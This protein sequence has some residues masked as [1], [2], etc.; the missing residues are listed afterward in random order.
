MLNSLPVR[1]DGYLVDGFGAELV[2]V[3]SGG[4]PSPPT[5]T[6]GADYPPSSVVDDVATWSLTPTEAAA[7]KASAGNSV[8][9]AYVVTVGAGDAKRPVCTGELKFAKRGQGRS[10]TVG[11]VTVVIGPPGAAGVQ[12]ATLD[13]A[14]ASLS[15]TYDARSPLGAVRYVD[16]TAGSDANDGR[17]WGKAKATVAAGVSSLA[18][19][20]TVCVR[21]G[22]YLSTTTI[23]IAYN[24]TIV[25][26]SVRT[27]TLAMGNSA[28]CNMFEVATTV[29]GF[30]VRSMDLYGNKAHNTAGSG[31]VYLDEAGVTYRGT[32][33]LQDINA[34]D[35]AV[36]GIYLGRMRSAGY[37]T[38][39]AA[40]SN[41]RHGIHCSDDS[42]DSLI[43]SPDLGTNAGAGL[44]LNGSNNTLTGGTIY[45]SDNLIIEDTRTSKFLCTGTVL[46]ASNYDAVVINTDAGD[47]VNIHSYTGITMGRV[48][49]LAPATSAAFKSAT[50]GRLS[51]SGHIYKKAADTSPAYIFDLPATAVINDSG[52][53][54][55]PGGFTV[56]LSKNSSTDSSVIRLDNMSTL[57][58]TASASH[59]GSLLPC[60][61]LDATTVEYA[62]A[63][64]VLPRA[65]NSF[66]VTAEVANAGAGAGSHCLRLAYVILTAGDTVTGAT[67]GSTITT[68]AAAQNVLQRVTLATGIA[69][70]P[71][72]TVSLRVDRRAADA[73]DT[74]ANDIG[75]SAIIVRRTS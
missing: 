14:I 28:N 48:G 63:Q 15:S 13:A 46:E 18:G 33:R 36:D 64:V 43:L 75:I 70:S 26:D 72:K 62:C 16:G 17:S 3:S 32:G 73:G 20:G 24:T 50:L 40:G 4:W 55:Q 21:A 69:N 23:P 56:A 57:G 22:Y 11:P 12:Q 35:F 66:E 53:V 47:D 37:L 71:G 67:T 60:L 38:N 54:V 61:L 42:Q 65:W 45:G 31:I 6:A 52:L 68:V 19:A 41:G 10:S 44:Y 9:A 25:G 51:V 5:L 7:V 1:Q 58:S 29:V 2:V 27:T 74:L 49:L 59:L 8:A 39:V 30:N 34:H